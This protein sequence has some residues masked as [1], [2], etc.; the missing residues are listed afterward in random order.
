MKRRS[1]F[2]EREISRG[3]PSPPLKFQLQTR[4][5]PARFACSCC[6]VR[7]SSE[8]VRSTP[9]AYCRTGRVR[10]PFGHLPHPAHQVPQPRLLH[11][12]QGPRCDAPPAGRPACAPA[13]PPRRPFR[14][15]C[16][17]RIALARS[18]LLPDRARATN[19]GTNPGVPTLPGPCRPSSTSTALARTRASGSFRQPFDQRVQRHRRHVAQQGDR[20]GPQP[21]GWGQHTEAGSAP[22]PPAW[23]RPARPPSAS[24]FSRSFTRRRPWSTARRQAAVQAGS[25]RSGI[26]FSSARPAVRRWVASMLSK[27]AQNW[28]NPA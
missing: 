14:S 25:A 9:M 21:A 7:I 23:P 24:A 1:G 6:W 20:L 3:K 28:S 15:R 19:V 18:R 11:R 16:S 8:T 17:A 2:E 26:I 10:V 13:R 22:A 12:P 4:S 27:L 5:H